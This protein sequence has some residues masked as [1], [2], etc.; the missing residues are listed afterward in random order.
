LPNQTV[1]CRITRNFLC[2]PDD[3]LAKSGSAFF[4]V[5]G[6]FVRFAACWLAYKPG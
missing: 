2:E 4:Q 5:K 3:R 6:M 1:I